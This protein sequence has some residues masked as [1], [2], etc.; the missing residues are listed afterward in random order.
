[1]SAKHKDHKELIYFKE[2]WAES[3]PAPQSLT[4]PTGPKTLLLFVD[5]ENAED[6]GLAEEL[7]R[8]FKVITVR[9]GPFFQKDL[10]DQYTIDPLSEQDYA[11]LLTS[12]I[13]DSLP[14]AYIAMLWND[15][16]KQDTFV[17]P[18][19]S[20]IYSIFYLV[21][22]YSALKL[23][24]NVRWIS[25]FRA[26]GEPQLIAHS[27]GAYAKSLE[28]VYPRLRF[29][30]LEVGSEVNNLAEIIQQECLM[31]RY[32][33]AQEVRYTNGLRYEKQFTELS[34]ESGENALKQGGVYIISGGAGAL[35]LILSEYLAKVYQAKLILLGRRSI[36][37]SIEEKL[38][39]WQGYGAEVE[40]QTCDITN[41]ADVKRLIQEVK[42]R[43]GEIHGVIHAAGKA[44]TQLVFQKQI[45][46][47]EEILQPK[48]EGALLLDEATRDEPLDFFVTFSSTS[49]VMG[50][51]GQCDYAVANRFL[52]HFC[53]YRNQL[54]AEGRRQGRSISINW[55]L[56]ESGGMHLENQGEQ[57]YLQTSGMGY[58]TTELGLGAFA[59]IMSGQARQVAILYG[60]RKRL[61]TQ[62]RLKPMDA[63][64]AKGGAT[65]LDNLTGST[66]GELK[67]SMEEQLM[68]DVLHLAAQILQTQ[69]GKL[70]ADENM[71]DFGFDSIS[72]KEFADGLSELYDI[73][74]SP[75]V[76]FAK[77]TLND[78]CQFLLEDFSEEIGSHYAVKE[79]PQE[80]DQML[81]VPYVAESLNEP[82]EQPDF[83]ESQPQAQTPVLQPL[84][85][86]Y[87]GRKKTKEKSVPEK[88]AR[89]V[90]VIGM[91]FKLPGAETIEELWRMLEQQENQV[92][93]IPA[94]RWDW[95]TYYSADQ[96][97]EN[98]TNSRWGGFVAGHDTFDAKFFQLSP[99]E[100]ELMD[101]QQRLFIQA[102]WKAV[103]DSGYKMSALAGKQVGVF[104]GVQF[105]DYQQLLSANMDKVYAQSSIGNATALLSN[106][107]SF[108]FNFKGPS[109][110]IDT[111]CSSSLVA[112]HRAVKSIQHG[113]SDM[114]VAGGVSLM[115]D[116]N[117]YV[118]AGVMG[119][120]SP[121]GK[122]KTFDRSANGYVKGEG[123]GVVVLKPLD[124]AVKDGDHIYGVITGTA[125]NH[126][127]RAHS[128]TAP[129]SDAQA[130]L[131]LKAYTEAAIDPSWVSYIETH[132]TGTELGDPVEINGL[133]KAFSELYSRWNKA[134]VSGPQIGLGAFKTNIGHL[135]PASGIAGVIKV[136]V[137]LKQGKLP[138]NL[139]FNEL[140]P[141]IQLDDSPFYVL[142]RTR[143][144]GTAVDERG[145]SLPRCAGVSSFGFGGTNA[146]AVI[147]EYL[148]EPVPA[149]QIAKTAKPM[150]FILSAK[151]RDRLTEYAH[152]F[153]T[154]LDQ[155][156]DLGQVAY[157]LQVGREE[158]D[159]RLAIVASTA[160][161]VQH[162]LTAFSEGREMSGLY[163]GSIK[164]LRSA[165]GHP[166]PSSPDLAMALETANL[167][168]LAQ[169][170]AAGEAI[171][172]EKLYP[173]KRPARIPLPTYPFAPTRYWMPLKAS[174]KADTPVAALHALI[175]R[176]ISTL[177]EQG[178][179]KTFRGDEFYIADHGHVLPGVVYLEM[180]RA[181]GNMADD[182]HTVTGIRNVVWS[183]P[184]IVDKEARSIKTVLQPGNQGIEFQ[185]YSEQAG[186]R[187]DHAQGRLELGSSEAQHRENMDIAAVIRRCN[188]GEREAGNYYDLL[189]RLGAELGSRFRGIQALYCNPSEAISRL[190]VSDS[191]EHTLNDF[192]LH[193]TLT[194]GGLQSAVAYAYQTGLIDQ[195][196]LFVPFVLGHLEI[197]HSSAK[198]A[199]AYVQQ[200]KVQGLKFDIAF[201]DEAGQVVARMSELTI[202]PFQV[203]QMT[204]G[205]EN[206]QQVSTDLVYLTPTW[207][208]S[209]RAAAEKLS[210]TRSRQMVIGHK[211]DLE[212]NKESFAGQAIS[213]SFG[214][215]FKAYGTNRYEIDPAN[216]D[217][218]RKLADAC[219]LQED[220]QLQI[221]YLLGAP[222]SRTSK[223]M[224]DEEVYPVFHLCK[225]LTSM[226]LKHTVRL[227]CVYHNKE[228]VAEYSALAGFF[229]SIALE[230]SRLE[231]RL[232][233][234]RDAAKLK[235]VLEYELLGS[236]NENEVKYEENLRYTKQ[237]K[238]LEPAH[239]QTR[240]LKDRGV[241]MIV[242]GLG[243]LGFIF[244]K[245][246]AK[247]YQARLVL[248]GRSQHADIT[249]LNE[250]KALGAE[251]I[252]I[253]M[254]LSRAEAVEM[255]VRTA[256][257]SF[258]KLD[259]VLHCAGVIKDSLLAKK[260]LTE[261][262]DVLKPKVYGTMNLYQALEHENLDLFVPFSSSTSLIG[263][264]GQG[265]YAYANSFMDHYVTLM[266]KKTGRTDSVLNWSLWK[267]GGMQVDSA[268]EQMLFSKFG[269]SPLSD[270]H[271]IKAFEDS[272]SLSH[273]Q[274]MAVSGARERIIQSFTSRERQSIRQAAAVTAASP[275]S[276]E[277]TNQLAHAIIGIMSGILKSDRGDIS[278]DSDLSE[279]GFDSISFTELSNE[280]NRAL[281]VDITPTLFFEQSTPLAIAGAIYSEYSA[282]IDTYFS[283]GKVAT[284]YT[285]KTEPSV[286]T[287][288]PDTAFRQ[289]IRKEAAPVEWHNNSP[290]K[291]D[292]E[293][294]AIVGM[295]GAMPGSDNLEQ[296][297]ENL[298]AK[299][300]MVTT[301][302]ENR[303]NWQSR[304][305]DPRSEQGKTDVKYGAF[306]KDIDTFDPLFF[307][308]SPVE[309]EKMDP[310]ERVMLQTVW[311]TLENAGYKPD[312]L[313]GTRT[314]VFI[315]VSN[316]DYQEL[317]LKEEIATTLTRTML[318]NR[319]SYF[320]NWSGPSEP[321]DTACSSSLV[322]IHRAVESIWH[323]NCKYAVAGG[324]NLISSPNLF[325]AGSSLGM[326]SKDGKCKT[327][328]K[329]ADGYVR[330]EGAGALLLKPL[331]AAIRDKDYIHGVI[332]GTAV[333]HGGKSNSITSPNAK[334]QADVIIQAHERAGIDPS[335]VTYIE[336]HGTGTSLGD[337]IEV[338]G[339]KKAFKT[340]FQ[341]WGKPESELPQCVLG[342]VKTNIGHLESAAGMASIS[343][344]LLSMKHRKIPGNIHFNELNPYI[345]L[346][347]SGLT[348]AG[349]SASWE[350]L[351]D[352][353]RRE[354]PRRAGISSFGVGGSNAHIVV[355]EYQNQHVDVPA[356]TRNRNIIVLSAKSQSSLIQN[357]RSLQEFV[358]RSIAGSVSES[359]QIQ[360]ANLEL[361]LRQDVV[362]LFKDV[363]MFGPE[364]IELE[365]GLEEYGLDAV[366]SV[367]LME[368]IKDKYNLE[369]KDSIY[370]FSSLQS[371]IN[372]L[373]H[374][375]TGRISQYYADEHKAP[376]IDEHEP[377]EQLTLDKLAYNL[378]TG[379]AELS[380]RVAIVADS[381]DM[382]HNKLEAYLNGQKEVSGIYVGQS[383]KRT[384]LSRLFDGEESRLFMNELMMSEKLDKIAQLW[385]QGIQID[386]SSWYEEPM[387]KT[388]LPEYAFD[389]ERY[390]L[391]KRESAHDMR[392]VERVDSEPENDPVTLDDEQLLQLLTKVQ[393]GEMS[394]ENLNLLVGD[395]LE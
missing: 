354:I 85:H 309:A 301:I 305:G 121:D 238:P 315:G 204:G 383:S 241:Y 285:A 183:N 342:S 388:P 345:K 199:Y 255:A 356:K 60:E 63:V 387:R 350:A 365:A 148:R 143:E 322:A 218:Y 100:A 258:H 288:I 225:W 334:S 272:L 344:V 14:V 147:Q 293:P 96:Q 173:A 316:G 155:D 335:T 283:A 48:V 107:V 144:W 250:L 208:E 54:A 249:K 118:G 298:E 151:N 281:G 232:I 242:G 129:N 312:D 251:A 161:E 267:N 59:S 84:E 371:L 369:F 380:E 291:V 83:P 278:L 114:A 234:V 23:K 44:S 132:G 340:L 58:L 177:Y 124:Q 295:S 78:L 153:S 259:G 145:N 163:T 47:F 357:C 341:K 321:I 170:W 184:I 87:S 93:E 366:K 175:D 202:R 289:M 67:T 150:L 91:S 391:P 116:P 66:S 73:E 270:E 216:M 40:Y 166:E 162:K 359:G 253:P 269:M 6:D 332:R 109:E 181:A 26:S 373:L 56:W 146:H 36:Q 32:G 4:L 231:C 3:T 28:R 220:E 254:D 247:N 302:P 179:E 43:Y 282:I 190:E 395:L 207:V 69:P 11:R 198:A 57:L 19:T 22:A 136:L 260:D 119:V 191:L 165:A 156:A 186:Q 111:A 9:R 386:W 348:I 374:H 88:A 30:H 2:L 200:S 18:D 240:K 211:S 189:G 194:D 122:C 205:S 222:D 271:G 339:L 24:M 167:A 375:D 127:G 243:G 117:T 196:V 277:R 182:K 358:G 157:T 171:Q 197:Y 61:E 71:G 394:A 27:S 20:G 105:S 33:F 244:A 108:M 110:S 125:E 307:G 224:I 49:S 324:I 130:E 142:D 149:G 81:T 180:A 370:G 25:L 139:H 38:H 45:A 326:L 62:L 72:L 235:Q 279:L 39:E 320:F 138:G 284:G 215:A 74:L 338:E 133:K 393:K 362:S 353:H 230:N 55:P 120:F 15:R 264:I 76:F 361:A 37:S 296:F 106:R 103:E 80:Q 5:P 160:Q 233:E 135:E 50:D 10:D 330:G 390:W 193:P 201:L 223:E 381:L 273:S 21:K 275:E 347:G 303:W 287:V 168:T 65:E 212:A 68:Q 89:E 95:K 35:G 328:D 263:N 185:V 245:H 266:N 1:M 379:R 268:T 51:F 75:A 209:S 97:A 246:L 17:K 376:Q 367:R 363:M 134:P 92:H 229:R 42:Q 299:R 128:L 257:K 131:L 115:L 104:S 306:L 176:N 31:S 349:E 154:F 378:H 13:K 99:R 188:G 236:S 213:V 7:S 102:V 227:C 126:G 297:W 29:T 294:V 313:S 192:L 86:K 140:N 304:F 360:E 64:Q 392:V 79:L 174:G 52:D 314:S 274:V 152:T 70:N 337:P 310:Q 217:D 8:N 286:Q 311:H 329:D 178:F 77:S 172:W 113:E 112:L 203:E 317:L 12:I 327:F 228:T 256:K 239:D 368:A 252:Y 41:S 290:Q 377:I 82:A 90:A 351:R 333:N 137:S 352:E 214:A 248:C 280:I 389:K 98:K 16:T 308:I 319:I 265:D 318:T 292:R 46:D 276:E 237:L 101:P 195:H 210:S 343:K 159:E 123:I 226:K 169:A 325:I 372:F 141:Y 323:D 261:I 382:L 219:L 355:E 384:P 346:D 164:K 300:D 187:I 262:E 364:E 385:V 34:L 94:D 206:K 53:R 221:V 336:T 158:M 331:S